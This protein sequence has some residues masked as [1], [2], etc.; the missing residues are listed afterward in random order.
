MI[1]EHSNTILALVFWVH[2]GCPRQYV[3]SN[4]FHHDGQPIGNTKCVLVLVE[5]DTK[6]NILNYIVLIRL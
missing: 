2:F 4:S 5:L 3:D 1:L 6:D